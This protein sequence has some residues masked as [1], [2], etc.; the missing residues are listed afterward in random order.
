MMHMSE[1]AVPD[2]NE[3]WDEGRRQR[4]LAFFRWLPTRPWED[5]NSAPTVDNDALRALWRKEL[6][7]NE[8]RALW[9]NIIRFRSWA[10]ALCNIM[11]EEYK[12]SRKDGK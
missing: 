7:L 12:A 10:H 1:N 11:V 2:E 3:H 4:A 5:E 9:D 8:S 6:N